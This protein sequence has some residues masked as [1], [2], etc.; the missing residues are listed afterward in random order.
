MNGPTVNRMTMVPNDREAPSGAQFACNK[1]FLFQL[2]TCPIY[3]C[4]GQYW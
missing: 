1:P 2:E 3:F 4:Y